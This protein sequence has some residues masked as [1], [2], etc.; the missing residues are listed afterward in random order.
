LANKRGE[1][2][3]G[4]KFFNRAEALL[5]GAP[6]VRDLLI[7]I[8]ERVME[9]SGQETV[10]SEGNPLIGSIADIPMDVFP[11]AIRKL[12]STL[13]EIGRQGQDVELPEEEEPEEPFLEEEEEE[14]D[15][16]LSPDAIEALRKRV[17]RLGRRRRG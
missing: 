4:A 3:S 11:I 7:N 10:D 8:S 12:D 2:L 15:E 1:K 6:G 5:G 14:E 16:D 13:E 9:G 17:I